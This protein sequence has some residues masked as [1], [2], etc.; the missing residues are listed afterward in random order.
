MEEEEPPAQFVREEDLYSDDS[1]D[2][3]SIPDEDYDSLDERS[4]P[5]EDCDNHLLDFNRHTP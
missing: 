3:R 5:D 1:L 4:I 2:E